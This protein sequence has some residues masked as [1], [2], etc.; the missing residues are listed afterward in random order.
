MRT[1]SNVAILAC[2][3]AMFSTV[4]MRSSGADGRS[5]GT[6]DGLR[7]TLDVGVVFRLDHNAG[8]RLGAGVAKNDPPIL[9]ERGLRFRQGAGH[10]RERLEGWL[11]FNSHV[12]DDLRVVFQTL[13]ERFQRA[14]CG[15]QGSHF[16]RS[17]EA[18]AGWAIVEEND[19]ARLLA[20][21][22]VARLEHFLEDIA[23]ADGSA[24]ERN[25][26]A[27][28]YAFQA[29]IGHG[30]G[31]HAL[32]LQRISRFQVTRHGQKNAITIDDASAA[33]DEQ[34]AVSVAIERHAEQ[35]LFGQHAFQ[36]TVKIKGTAT[37]VDVASVGIHPHG[38][39]VRTQTLKQFWA[40]LV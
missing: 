33:A 40:Q 13:N 4:S 2:Q 3:L 31:H 34:R 21:E 20:T 8:E 10:F 7:K 28:Q 29:K 35:S 22:I 9:P 25:P 39:D 12:D 18:I 15:N 37:G 23:I 19:V 5:Q 30:S 17:E 27:I 32:A 26:F 36:Q 1:A 16:D 11:G 24:S 38:N 14:V 6:G